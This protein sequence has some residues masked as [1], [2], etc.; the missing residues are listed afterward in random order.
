MSRPLLGALP[1]LALAAA[2]A[3]AAPALA[4]PAQGTASEDAWRF[5]LS[6]PVSYAYGHTTYR[7]EASDFANSV[8]SEL[9]FPIRTGLV[10]ARARLAGARQVRRGGPA[11]EV[12]GQLAVRSQDTAKMKDSDWLD[13]PD[14][15]PGGVPGGLDIYSE[16]NAKLDA[17]V[18]EGRFAWEMDGSSP[19]VLFAPMLGVLYQR[20][21]YAVSDATQV[22]YG[23]FARNPIF[24]G[25]PVLEY[26]V[27]YVLPYLGARAEIARGTFTGTA[28]AWFS[29]FAQA[30]DLD[31]HLRRGKTART[32]A[33]G[34]ALS[35]TVA[36][37]FALGARSSVRAEA[38][39]VRIST[40]GTQ[41]QHWYSNDPPGTS[42]SQCSL[43][44]DCV[45]AGT[46]IRGI[47]TEI[48]SLRATFGLAYVLSL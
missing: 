38:S 9:A 4:A 32:D 30:D 26:D 16:S 44:P 18:L 17:R 20:F 11:F 21:D 25:G 35:A 19:G 42:D 34:T 37:R 33:S 41:D 15:D 14:L 13:G 22:G 8:A 40:S 6:V 48:T 2:L 45:P 5:E 36:A 47:P 29:P 31:D 1:V 27:T 10:G 23:N 43:D 3:P 7:I 28:E 24:L 46:E 39:L 12:S